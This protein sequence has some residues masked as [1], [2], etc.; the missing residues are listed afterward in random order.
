LKLLPEGDRGDNGVFVGVTGE[1]LRVNEKK[2]QI[3]VK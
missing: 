3:M 1:G 2:Q